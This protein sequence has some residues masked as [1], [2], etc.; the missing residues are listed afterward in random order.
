MAFDAPLRVEHLKEQEAA[1]NG[2]QS[3]ELA[4]P[5]RNSVVHFPIGT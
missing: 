1:A 2:N 4:Q 5:N 3:E